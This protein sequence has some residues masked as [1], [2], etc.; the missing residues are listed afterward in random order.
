MRGMAPMMVSRYDLNP[1]SLPP[2]NG[3]DVDS[4]CSSGRW[5]RSAVITRMRESAS[6]KPAWTCMPP[7]TSRRRLSW[8]VTAKRS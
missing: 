2:L 5:R 3:D 6:P 4:A 8:N 1:V 7:M